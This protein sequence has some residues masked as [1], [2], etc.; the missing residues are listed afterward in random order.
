MRNPANDPPYRDRNAKK[1][2]KPQRDV[3]ESKNQGRN[4]SVNCNFKREQGNPSSTNE[5]NSEMS[6]ASL[7]GKRRNVVSKIN[8]T[9]FG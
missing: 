8:V 7:F 3:R 1:M 6:F 2:Y 4:N 5:Y 9:D